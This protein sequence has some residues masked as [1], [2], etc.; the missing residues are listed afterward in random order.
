M[1]KALPCP[2]PE[3]SVAG[4]G[5][6]HPALQIPALGGCVGLG[7]RNKG[8]LSLA[9]PAQGP[10]EFLGCFYGLLPMHRQSW[11]PS[12]LLPLKALHSHPGWKEV[13]EKATHMVKCKGARR[14]GGQSTPQELPAPGWERGQ[15]AQGSGQAAELQPGCSAKA[16]NHGRGVSKGGNKGHGEMPR[17][18]A[19]KDRGGCTRGWRL[20]KASEP[21]QEG[22]SPRDKS[23]PCSA[24]PQP[25]PVSMGHVGQGNGAS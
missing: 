15:G 19:G 22:P 4:S 20:R 7:C 23:W 17:H 2:G 24:S 12:N 8:R 14:Q 13:K 11:A 9:H 18:L 25:S 6:T 1:G 21:A 5:S 3:C 16:I 10:G